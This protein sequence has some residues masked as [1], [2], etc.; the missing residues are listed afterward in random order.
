MDAVEVFRAAVGEP[1]AWQA[2]ALRSQASRKL[3]NV[4]RQGGKSETASALAVHATVYFRRSL[5]LLVSPTLRQSGELFRKCMDVYRALGCPVPSVSETTLS[6]ELANGSRIIS[7]PGSETS[8]RGYS[9]PDLVVID[10]AS[11]VDDEVFHSV[12]PTMATNRGSRLLC[13]STPYGRRGWWSDLWHDGGD[14]WERVKV[15]AT[16]CPRISEEFLA[17]EQAIK[18]SW[19]YRQEYECCFEAAEGALFDPDWIADAFTDE[20]QPFVFGG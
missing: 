14:T 19:Y 15:P 16:D 5:V 2:A 6:L 3:W 18:P 13:L 1:D 17:A 20:V 8:I 9:A 12:T 7:L 4:T 10:E 11:R